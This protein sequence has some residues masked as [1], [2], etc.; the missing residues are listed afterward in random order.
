MQELV[1]PPI[2]LQPALLVIR[3]S[4]PLIAPIARRN[5]IAVPTTSRRGVQQQLLLNT[6]VLPQS[7]R[8]HIP[9]QVKLVRPR[10]GKHVLPTK[11]QRAD[12][13]SVEALARLWVSVRDAGGDQRVAVV[14]VHGQ[15][16]GRVNDILAD[17]VA[18]LHQGVQVVACGVHGDPSRVIAWRWRIDAADQLDL[19]RGELAVGPELVGGQVG[20]V[21]V[22]LCRVEDHAVDARVGLVGVVLEVGVEG[23]GG[24]DG[25]DVA[26]AGV[27]VEGV[28]VDGVGG[29]FGGKEEDGAGVGF[30]VVC[31]GCCG[32]STMHSGVG[33]GVV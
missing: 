22:A 1:L 31:L 8:S 29:L 3:N 28:A 27:L 30:G 4:N 32:T 13:G 11:S 25:E 14:R 5:S 33:R 24:G 20:R 15:V 9:L 16:G 2:H 21:E 18:R 7:K 26:V 10:R 19:A 17:A 6:P 23:A 12:V